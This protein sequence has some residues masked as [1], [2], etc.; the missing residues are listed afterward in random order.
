M[1]FLEGTLESLSRDQG[2]FE[3]LRRSLYRELNPSWNRVF[4]PRGEGV[5]FRIF[6]RET[7]LSVD[8]FFFLGF[9]FFK[10]SIERYL[11]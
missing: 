10:F 7:C 5:S 6:T 1:R 3:K 11:N 8:Y 4:D 9:F 2:C